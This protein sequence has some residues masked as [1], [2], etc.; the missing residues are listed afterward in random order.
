MKIF[1]IG[2][3]G[4]GKSSYASE[5]AKILNFKYLDTDDF[6]KNKE[7]MSIND[8]FQNKGEKYFREIENQVLQ[9]DLLTQK[10]CVISTGG[11]TPQ[12]FDN[13]DFMNKNGITVFLKLDEETIYK[14]LKKS[15]FDRPLIK[16]MTDTELLVFIQEMYKKRKK[17]YNKAQIVISPLIMKAKM[18]KRFF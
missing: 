1:L 16:D 12:F 18:L 3:M 9:N 15:K 2:F 8:I 13:M 4:S 17:Y 11:G 7:G 10:Y 6:I 5:L 14:R